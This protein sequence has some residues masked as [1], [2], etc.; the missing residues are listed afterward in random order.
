MTDTRPVAIVTGGAKRV[1]R[2][3]VLKMASAGYDVAFTYNSSRKDADDLVK[4]LG[5]KGRKA[6]AIKA[7]LTKPEKSAV[8]VYERVAEAFSSVALLVNNASL[9]EPGGLAEAT[10]EQSRRLHAI[11]VESPM[12]L[13]QRFEPMLR[14]AKGHV[15]NMVDLLAERPWPQYLAYCASKAS[16]LNLTLGLARSLAPDVTVNGIAPGV[17]EWP[18]DYPEAE[19]ENYLKRVPLARPGTPEDVADLVHFLATSGRYITGQIIHLD[20]GRSIT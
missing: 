12:L 3:I 17:V 14:A 9:Y 16:L 2:A 8:T 5:Q 20:G 13:C 15:V 1:G 11:H 4:S 19:R 10:A 18:A 6:L 7:D